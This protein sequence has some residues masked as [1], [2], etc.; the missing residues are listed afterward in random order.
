ME[1]SME[2]IGN[3][4]LDDT[5][6]PGKDLYSDG[7]VE[8]HILKLV[9]THS[10][11]EYPQV[12]A[13]ERDWAVMYHLAHERENILSWYPFA[14]GAK[15]LEVGSGCGAVTGAVAA[16][17]ESVTCIDLSKKRS[18]V[19]AV[20]HK[21]SSNITIRLG[22]FQDVEKDLDEDFDYATLIGVFEYGRGYI[23]GEKPYHGFLDAVMKH[24]RPGGKLLLAIENKFGLKYWAGCREDHAGMYFEGLEGYQ[25]TEGVR[26]FS[27]PELIRIMEECGFT[28]YKFY[29]P[30]PD[31][32]LPAVI[33]S[34]GYLPRTGELNR[35]ICNFDR[36]RLVLMDEGK[37]FDQILKD[38]LFP[39]YAN[40]FFVEITKPE[41]KEKRTDSTQKEEME[42]NHPE[43]ILYTKYSSG[44]NR[45]FSIQTRIVRDIDGENRLYKKAEYPEGQ[46][47]I[48]HIAEAGKR[49]GALWQ[50]KGKLLVNRSVLKDDYIEFEY[51][52]GV[53]VEEELDELLARG[54]WQE[55]ADVLRAAVNQI[56]ESARTEGYQ[57]TPEFQRVFGEASIMSGEPAFPVA[58]VDLIFSNI[59]KSKD[60]SW[61]VLDYEWTFFFPVP[62]SFLL[63]RALHYYL[64][65]A[66]VRKEFGKQFDFYG[67][68][69]ITQEQ[70]E[71]YLKMEQRFQRFVAGGSIS[72]GSLYH[73]MGKKAV[74]LADLLAEADR[75]RVQVY[76]DHGHGFSE[77]DSYF[78][79]TGFDKT[80]QYTITLS[81]QVTGISVDPALSACLLEDVRLTWLCGESGEEI[82]ASYR[83]NGYKIRKNSYLFDNPDPKIIIKEI[84]KQCRSLVVS[85][86][87]NILEDETAALLNTKGRMKKIVR[88]LIKG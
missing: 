54:K 7:A 62:V 35:N 10:E 21:D 23:G 50:E 37:V 40:S 27:R 46:E 32:K 19:N 45:E 53:T 81:E 42:R 36:D 86:R 57:M 18:T 51:L 17:A 14:P 59:L 60:G 67:E 69:G 28:D 4:I 3:V 20:R 55:A 52:E 80:L 74:P 2:Q 68:F 48:A 22:N 16:S 88:R 11:T 38:G 41:D 66:S 58:D 56:R 9:Q 77:Q 24:I 82:P 78:I 44:R 39:L 47:H 1:E 63:F 72:P 87:I 26:T 43:Q 85:Y 64:E 75:R 15:V 84:P 49:L 29:Y 30:Y 76:L 79:E 25:H 31:Y 83:T 70:H 12:I 71:V 5:H 33:Y 13:R 65:S 73:T 6:Y 61:N 8:D 34:D